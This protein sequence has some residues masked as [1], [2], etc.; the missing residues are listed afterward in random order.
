MISASGID[1]RLGS[2]PVLRGLELRVDAGEVVAVTGPNG[3][4][5]STLLRLLAT[6]I[7]P[8]A[9][10][11]ELFDRCVSPRDLQTM[12]KAIGYLGHE[13]ALHPDLTVSENLQLVARLRGGTPDAVNGAL[14]DVGLS[15]AADRRV[16]VC[17]AG[18]RRRAELARVLVCRPDLLLLDEPHAA[19]DATARSLVDRVTSA[20]TSRGGAAVLVTHDPAGIAGIAPRLLSMSGGRLVEEVAR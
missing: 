7:P 3:S 13:P 6:L 16:R 19:L 9:G 11:L 20:V 17:S 10:R 12:R 1:V 8:S 2:M 4:G 18:M 5:K 15:A 14:A